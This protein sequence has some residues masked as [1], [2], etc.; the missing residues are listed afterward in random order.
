MSRVRRQLSPEPIREVGKVIRAVQL[1]RYLSDTPLRARVTAATNKV[2]ALNGFSHWGPSA[3][4]V[5]AT[6]RPPPAAGAACSQAPAAGT[7]T[8]VRDQATSTRLRRR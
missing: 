6:T 3:S 7:P 1:L 4:T 5:A 8:S 2:E